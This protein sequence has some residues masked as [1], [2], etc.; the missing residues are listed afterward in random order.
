MAEDTWHGIPR[1][2]IPWYPTIDHGKCIACGKCVQ[3]CHTKA[4]ET[5]EKEGKN[6]TVVAKPY[7]CVVTCT[8]CDSVCPVGAITHPS[9]KEFLV[10]IRELRKEYPIKQANEEHNL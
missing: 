1:G 7:N 10:K 5:E 2:K 3:F 9:K 8:G 4:F 6:E